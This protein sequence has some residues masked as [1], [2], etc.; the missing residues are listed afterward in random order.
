[1]DSNHRIPAYYP[2]IDA[3]LKSRESEGGPPPHPIQDE[4]QLLHTIKSPAKAGGP[5]SEG[6]RG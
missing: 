1:M 6:K 4:R 2:N 5:Q 3:G